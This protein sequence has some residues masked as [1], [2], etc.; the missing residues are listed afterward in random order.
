[1]NLKVFLLVNIV[2]AAC[3]PKFFFFLEN[4]PKL[5][6]YNS[7]SGCNCTTGPLALHE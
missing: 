1:V 6:F 7:A 5:L 3:V 2:G 4:I